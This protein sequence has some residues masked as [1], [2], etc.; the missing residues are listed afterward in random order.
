MR[1]FPFFLA[2]VLIGCVQEPIKDF[3]KTE[4]QKEA[5]S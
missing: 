5:E 4:A 1:W 2:I 3:S